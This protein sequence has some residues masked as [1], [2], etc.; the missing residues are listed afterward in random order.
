LPAI[1]L[2]WWD[3]THDRA[4]TATVP[5]VTLTVEAAAAVTTAPA[6]AARPT[7]ETQPVIATPLPA[8]ADDRS[9]VRF[10]QGLALVVT[11]LWIATMGFTLFALRRRRATAE[12]TRVPE[13][14][15]AQRRT[16]MAACQ[17]DD[18]ATA[19]RALLNWAR[20][21]QP[22]L[23]NLGELARLLDDPAQRA[24]IAD[25]E[26]CLYGVGAASGLAQTLMRTFKGGLRIR[27]AARE[28]PS[29]ALPQLYPF[30]T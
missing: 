22:Q 21:E 17:R 24:A 28:T 1:S 2:A 10:W 15:S 6:N 25:L 16:F 4:E 3:T 19:G 13:P 5:A 9:L 12:K 14:D 26:R 7:S 27:S 18:F 8:A 11:V 20:Q 30:R 29:G 23:C